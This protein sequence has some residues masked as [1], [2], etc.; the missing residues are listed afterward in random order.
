MEESITVYYHKDRKEQMA[1][2][3]NSRYLQ[4]TLQDTYRGRN[5]ERDGL[6]KWKGERSTR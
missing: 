4:L 2:R 6:I 3:M 1:L 5:T